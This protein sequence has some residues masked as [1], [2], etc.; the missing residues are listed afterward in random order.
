MAKKCLFKKNINRGH[1]TYYYMRV[2]CQVT[3]RLAGT[4]YVSSGSPTYRL[5]V[6]R[7][8]GRTESWTNRVNPGYPT[9]LQWSRDNTSYPPRGSPP[10]WCI[11][12]IMT[13]HQHHG[14]STHRPLDRL[15]NNCSSDLE[16]KSRNIQEYRKVYMDVS[17]L[18]TDSPCVVSQL[19][20]CMMIPFSDKSRRV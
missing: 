13:A 2:V 4:F 15:F 16:C 10:D 12:I 8:D 9:H 20:S 11:C 17:G 18:A 14:V 6:R 1:E 5:T 7:T 19:A 3:K